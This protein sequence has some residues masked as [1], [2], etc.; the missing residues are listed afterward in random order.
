NVAHRYCRLPEGVEEVWIQSSCIQSAIWHAEASGMAEK[1]SYFESAYVCSRDEEAWRGY[2]DIKCLLDLALDQRH[3]ENP[4][5][6][7]TL[8]G[9]GILPPVDSFTPSY[10]LLLRGMDEAIDQLDLHGI[11]AFRKR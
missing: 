11:S 8:S 10:R 1:G 4:K 5:V 3:R 9:F 6:P 2:H 7:N